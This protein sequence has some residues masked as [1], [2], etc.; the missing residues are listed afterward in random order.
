VLDAPSDNCTIYR[1]SKEGHPYLM[2]EFENI[3]DSDEYTFRVR[4]K[5]VKCSH[6][7]S[8]VEEFEENDNKYFVSE[9]IDSDL[10]KLAHS[11]P[12][13]VLQ[14]AQA[15]PYVAEL[16]ETLEELHSSKLVLRNM[17]PEKVRVKNG[18]PYLYDFSLSQFL[19]RKEKLFEVVGC[20]SFLAPDY[21]SEDGYGPEVDIWALG[22]LFFYL[23]LHEYPFH[24]KGDSE[25]AFKEEFKLKCQEGFSFGRALQ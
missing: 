6:L 24:F 4:K 23:L 1:V 5:L 20:A 15:L 11:R 7:V 8:L 22:V 19:K 14:L 2:H 3:N 17:R 21:Y 10:L 16:V 25:E 18:R 12:G 9:Y 13:H